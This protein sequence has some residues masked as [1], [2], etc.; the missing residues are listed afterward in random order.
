M[1]NLND[2]QRSELLLRGALTVDEDG[3]EVLLGLTLAESH[4]FLTF[5]E[6]PVETHAT[7]ETVLYYQLKHK[8]L[9]A[10]S[11]ALLGP[12]ERAHAPG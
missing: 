6:Q 12:A 3:D 11:A 7:G 10:R 8:H 2:G 4:F 5:E 9:A 1:L